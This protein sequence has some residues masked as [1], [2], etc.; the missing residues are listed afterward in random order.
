MY[1]KPS[2]EAD[3]IISVGGPSSYWSYTLLIFERFSFSILLLF[4]LSR[5][6]VG[7]M[8]LEYRGWYLLYLHD[9]L[10]SLEAG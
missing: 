1:P 4:H 5:T 8:P 6:K 3:L 10:D 2:G 9:K 7:I